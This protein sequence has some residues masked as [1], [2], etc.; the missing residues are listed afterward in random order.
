MCAQ[1]SDL[2]IS[3][4]VLLWLRALCW[5]GF[6]GFLSRARPRWS[7][8]TVARASVHMALVLCKT[9]SSCG[10]RLTTEFRSPVSAFVFYLRA[11]L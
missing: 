1:G 9:S 7:S 5:S 4:A 6:R 10:E 3:D 11:R 2:E 8:T